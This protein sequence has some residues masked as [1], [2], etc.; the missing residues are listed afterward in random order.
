M[1]LDHIFYSTHIRYLIHKKIRTEFQKL[2]NLL[3]VLEGGEV[4]RKFQLCRGFVILHGQYILSRS[5]TYIIYLIPQNRMFA[6]LKLNWTFF[7][8]T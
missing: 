1:I 7:L 8:N 4:K 6:Q 5:N 3:E 2:N